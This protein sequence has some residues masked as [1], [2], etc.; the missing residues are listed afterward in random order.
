M[1]KRQKYIISLL[2]L[3]IFPISAIGLNI[4]VHKCKHKGTI[5]LSFLESNKNIDDSKCCCPHN[6]LNIIEKKHHGSCCN[7]GKTQNK[8]Q[9]SSEAQMTKRADKKSKSCCQ[10]K[11][12]KIEISEK[13]NIKLQKEGF[14]NHYFKNICCS[15][16]DISYSIAVATAS[17][18]NS[19]G[20]IE[21]PTLFKT[22]SN[23]SN[24][25]ER[26]FNKLSV[27]EIQ[28]PLKGPICNIISFIHFTSETT[29]DAV[30]VPAF[31][32]LQIA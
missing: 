8:M 17:I 12:N 11:N 4:S 9:E 13:I 23:N 24:S 26:N 1:N 6:D 18:D 14:N 15:N 20:L 2:L 3:V 10:S 7:K 28:F 19:K 27:K 5:Y 29:D 31:M 16:S 21:F 22:L 25:N 30:P 32:L